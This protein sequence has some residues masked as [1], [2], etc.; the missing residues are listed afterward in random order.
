MKLDFVVAVF[1]RLKEAY[2]VQA[3]LEH[4]E[5]TIPTV[6]RQH[7]LDVE[8]VV[9]HDRLVDLGQQREGDE[10]VGREKRG[11]SVRLMLQERIVVDQTFAGLNSD[12]LSLSFATE[13]RF[14]NRMGFC[15]T[16][17]SGGDLRRRVQREASVIPPTA[18]LF[19]VEGIAG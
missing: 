10:P 17:L 2:V 15:P 4:V 1:A 18:K 6:E 16:Y 12:A 14:L 13:S 19:H 8:T 9:E 11:Q 3:E 5:D 7:P